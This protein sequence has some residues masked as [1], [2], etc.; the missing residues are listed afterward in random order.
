MSKTYDVTTAATLASG[1]Y[2]VSG[3]VDG[4]TVT[5]NNPTLGTYDTKNVGTGKTVTATG[6]SIASATNSAVTVYGYQLAS[7]SANGAVGTIA[8][9]TLTAGLT[10]TVSK[11]Y[12]ATTAAT[13]ASGNYSLSG[14]LGGD[15][16]NLNDPASGSYDTKNVG[17]GKTVTVTGLSISGTDA[18][19]YVLASTSAAAAI[20]TITAATLRPGLT[21]SVS[22]AYDGTT[23]ATLA[24]GNYSL[25]GVL[26]SDTVNLNN[27]TSG[28]YDTK[29]VGTGKTVTVTGLSISGTDA[30]NYVLASTSAAAAIGAITTATLTVTANDATRLQ[31]EPNPAFTSTISGF[32]SGE[33]ASLVS[34]LTITT[35]ATT[36]SPPGQYAIVASGATA[37]NY[38]FAYVD[39][40]LTVGPIL[41]PANT[42][43]DPLL[44]M[45]PQPN[46]S[47][48]DGG[49]G[50]TD[51]GTDTVGQCSPSPVCRDN[52]S[53]TTQIVGEGSV[54][55]V[56]LGA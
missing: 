3:S 49:D 24:S 47:G 26:G 4:D 51:P 16:V 22:K 54:Y 43:N 15:T 23:A 17:T 29:N 50:I 31:T 30:A 56:G 14:V 2:S 13:L 25:S 9:A 55:Y 32:A 21:G 36:A 46:D 48:M 1:N 44:R 37:P 12:D 41:T 52:P 45:T 42:I 5:L 7:T 39:G 28:T 18:A 10:G 38:V 27:P 40:V 19:N 8:A 35:G 6:I 11:T 53:S 34:G 33:D 20:G